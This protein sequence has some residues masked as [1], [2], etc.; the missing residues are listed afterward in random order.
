MAAESQFIDE[1][2]SVQPERTQN[3]H[4]CRARRAPALPALLCM[5]RE[6]FM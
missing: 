1:D 4:A 2:A 3:V 6:H 5:C